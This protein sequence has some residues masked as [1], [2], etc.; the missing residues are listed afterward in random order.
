MIFH[1]L[2]LPGKRCPFKSLAGRRRELLGKHQRLMIKRHFK[3]RVFLLKK[4]LTRS[5]ES[6][7]M[8]VLSQKK[9]ENFKA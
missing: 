8:S 7:P 4:V 6:A 5:E 2:S 9:L 3:R 1:I